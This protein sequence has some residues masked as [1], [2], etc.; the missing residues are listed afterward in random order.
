M[1]ILVSYDTQR[2]AGAKLGIVKCT[3]RAE[4]RRQLR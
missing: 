4:P 1:L 3:R 2:T